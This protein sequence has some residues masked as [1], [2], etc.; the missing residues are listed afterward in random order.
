MPITTT[1]K[2]SPSRQ[3][4]CGIAV[5]GMFVASVCYGGGADT[6]QPTAADSDTPAFRHAFTLTYET[7]D[8]ALNTPDRQLRFSPNGLSL[9]YS[10]TAQSGVFMNL[11]FGKFEDDLTFNNG[12][13]D[14]SNQ[15][16]RLGMGYQFQPWWALIQYTQEKDRATAHRAGLTTVDVIEHADFSAISAEISREYVIENAWL[17]IS[18]F[19]EY[20]EDEGLTETRLRSPQNQAG[21]RTT[22]DTDGTLLGLAASASYLYALSPDAALVPSLAI[23]WSEP[24]SGETRG[25]SVAASF[26]RD[27]SPRRLRLEESASP[28]GSGQ[29]SLGLMLLV[30]AFSVQ[31]AASFPFDGD[32]SGGELDDDKR[33]SVGVGINF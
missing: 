26:S 31:G 3:R 29:I 14:F 2:A 13:G 20:Q 8:Q 30:D 7:Y 9:Q 24:L 27:Q 10:L 12:T 22:N 17:A 21:Q 32:S 16:W 6:I 25:A 18:A 5:A 4:A 23:S 11:D 28:Q 1:A 15:R 19:A 33:L